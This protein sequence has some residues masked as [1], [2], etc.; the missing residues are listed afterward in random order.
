MKIRILLVSVLLVSLIAGIVMAG[1]FPVKVI[2]DRGREITIERWPRR[3]V[4]TSPTTTQILFDLGL[5]NQI[6]GVTSVANYLGYV[7]KIQERAME[8]M[9]IGDVDLNVEKI[10][11]LEP[12]LIV[13]GGGQDAVQEKFLSQFQRLG[14]TVYAMEADNI[15]HIT[16]N[17][18]ELGQITGAVA[19]SK[20]I[21]D[22]MNSRLSKLIETVNQLGYKKEVF[23][24]I[25]DEP[26]YTAGR[27]TFLGQVLELAGLKNV[28]YDLKGFKPVN[29]EN[30]IE[31]DPEVF[32]IT[33]GFSENLQSLKGRPGFKNITAV[34]NNDVIILTQAETSMIQQPGTKIVDGIIK[35]FERIYNQKVTEQ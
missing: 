26:L 18:I 2:D 33:S 7:P 22:H 14:L 15:K 31:R 19:R 10:V 25:W 32:V 21:V 17:I 8:K 16:E 27:D 9:G 5:D 20:E 1:Q 12:D 3:I 30:V 11:S 34:K 6:V 4:T 23:L 35:L 13:M 29:P 28:F 24:E